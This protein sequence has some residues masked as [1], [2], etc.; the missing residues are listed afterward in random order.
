MAATCMATSWASVLRV[1][2]PGHEVGLAIE[3][4]QGSD[5]AAAMDVRFNEPIIG[6]S[7]RLLSSGCDALL[8]EDSLG[9]IYVSI[10]GFERAL[11]VHY[12]GPGQVSEGLD[13][14]NCCC[15]F[16]SSVDCL[17][18]SSA[19]VSG[20]CSWAAASGGWGASGMSGASLGEIG[21]CRCAPVDS[22][23]DSIRDAGGDEPDGPDSVVVSGHRVV[24]EGRVAVGIYEGDDGYA[25][26]PRLRD[27]DGLFAHVR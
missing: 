20:G 23:D 21:L 16:Y 19:S 7:R 17:A 26:A 1:V 10:G 15:Q 11:G 27:G 2:G 4:D 14:F 22:L 18:G 24:D 5:S 6:L 8:P 3:F 25:D 13:C 12:P 9:G